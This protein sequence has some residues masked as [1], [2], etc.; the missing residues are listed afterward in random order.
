MKNPILL[1]SLVSLL[2]PSL[3]ASEPDSRLFELRTYFA[4][5]GK[6]EAL[7]ARFRNHT[8]PLFERHGMTQIGYWV[9]A[10]NTNHQLLYVLA[11]PNRSARDSAWKA[12]LADPDWLK[13]KSASETDGP[14][15]A[16][17][18]QHFLAATDFSPPIATTVS[19][20]PRVFELRTYTTTP[21][22]LGALFQRFRDHTIGLF[23]KHGMT[24]LFY[25]KLTSGEP[26]AENTLIYLL[27]H[28]SA[29][30]AAESFANFRKDPDWITARTASETKAGG[31]LT[32][33]E[34]VKSLFLTPT[35]YSPTR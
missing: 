34:G 9:P 17:V 35:D 21:G 12:F 8:V 19:T 26:S 7:N 27:A 13:A 14:L 3:P 18:E 29:Q 30:A 10:E 11:Y 1:T 16:K 4:V 31:S 24:N 28:P 2:A 23:A 5:P 20:Y 22:N 33:P 6:L 15:V 32:V 25:W